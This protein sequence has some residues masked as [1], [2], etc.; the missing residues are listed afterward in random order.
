M[1]GYEKFKGDEAARQRSHELQLS[2][3][4]P[5][6][7]QNAQ[8]EPTSQ[9]EQARLQ[10]RCVGGLPKVASKIDLDA[11]KEHPLNIKNSAAQHEAAASVASH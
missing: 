5:T 10:G 4:R 2:P 11:A 6:G 8:W 1:V 9:Q 7:P 3:P